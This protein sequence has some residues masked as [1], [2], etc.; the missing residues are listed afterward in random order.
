MDT[1]VCYFLQYSAHVNF[2]P[3]Y[4]FSNFKAFKVIFITCEKTHKNRKITMLLWIKSPG[5]HKGWLLPL[6]LCNLWP[7]VKWNRGHCFALI[8]CKR[9]ATGLWQFYCVHG[10]KETG[11]SKNVLFNTSH[12]TSRSLCQSY[13][14]MYSVHPHDKVW[15]PFK[16]KKDP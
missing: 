15:E 1:W 4:Q 7:H 9:R 12:C 8:T 2:F 6:H 10:K 14:Y 13:N 11:L 3:L 5:T 16:T